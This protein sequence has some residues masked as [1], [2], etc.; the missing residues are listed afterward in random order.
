MML[1]WSLSAF[2]PLKQGAAAVQA[3][4]SWQMSTPQEAA[5]PQLRK[6]VSLPSTPPTARLEYLASQ[7]SVRFDEQVEQYIVVDWMNDCSDEDMAASKYK[8]I[9][10]SRQSTKPKLE[11]TLAGNPRK[12]IEALPCTTL[13]YKRSI[14]EQTADSQSLCATGIPPSNPSQDTRQ[15]VMASRSPLWGCGSGHNGL[16]DW[17]SSGNSQAR[18]GGIGASLSGPDDRSKQSTTK[19]TGDTES[20]GTIL[21]SHHATIYDW[22]TDPSPLLRVSLITSALW[23]VL[24]VL[25]CWILWNRWY[26]LAVHYWSRHC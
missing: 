2:S 10:G 12:S 13:K 23:L 21:Q 18:Q 26:G 15:P 14:S 4:R 11:V 7:K 16:M 24:I 20:L 9:C 19:F 3:L 1:Q 8:Y 17:V 25:E 22:I 6:S 5:F